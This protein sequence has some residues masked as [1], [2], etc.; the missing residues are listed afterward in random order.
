M[1]R[2]YAVSMSWPVYTFAHIPDLPHLHPPALVAVFGDPVAHSRSPQMHNPGLA[3]RGLEAQYVRL[4]I[5]PEEFVSAVYACRKAGFA[6]INCTIPHKLAALA[7][8]DEIDP[9]ARRLGAVNTLVFRENKILGY[10]TDGPGLLRALDEEFSL[11]LAN[12]RILILGAGGGAG[13]AAAIQCALVGCAGL[14]LVNRTKEK[15]ERLAHELGAFYRSDRLSLQTEPDLRNIDLVINASSV[16][17]KPPE[18]PLSA[19]SVL[20]SYHHVY[21]MIYS[22]PETAMLA[23][24]RAVGARAA[25]GL[26]MLLHQGAAS[27]EYWFGAPAPLETMR[28]GLLDSL[29]E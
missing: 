10:N 15:V 9:L 22:P 6:G 5:K 19:T 8:A 25:N 2:D 28:R 13:R 20:E 17:M 21:D 23:A 18:S 11:P 12:Q 3:A 26:S 16:G 27:F 1:I 29:P 4:Q 24:A 7:V 14:T